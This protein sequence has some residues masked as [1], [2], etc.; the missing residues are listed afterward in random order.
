MSIQHALLTSLLEKPSTGY[1]LARRFDKS[2]GYFWHASHQQI[3]RELGRMAEAGW[4]LATDDNEAGKRRRRLYQVLAPGRDELARWVSASETDGD[5]SRALLIKLRA[6]AVIGP[7]GLDRELRRLMEQHQ[8]RLD[9]YLEIEQR[10]FAA[11]RM[12]SAQK[13]RHAVLRAGIMAEQS[14]L[15]WAG[16]VLPVLQAARRVAAHA[17]PDPKP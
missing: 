9:T 5:A 16:E 14:W 4:I 7:H 15:E 3:Y 12:S 11:R 6:E 2:M 10:D 13:L 1:D 8:A 17:N